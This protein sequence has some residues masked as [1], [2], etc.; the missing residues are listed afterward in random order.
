V[1]DFSNAMPDANGNF[2]ADPLFVR[3]PGGNGASDFGDLHLQ[4]GSPAIDV[5]NDAA[6]IVPPFPANLNGQPLDLDGNP[7]ISRA[8]VDLGA[9]EYQ[10][11]APIVNAGGN[12]TVTAAHTGNPATDTASLSLNGSATDPENDPLTYTWTDANGNVVGNSLT[13]MLTLHLGAYTYTLTANAPFGASG[14]QSVLITVNPAP[15]QAP[16]ANSQNLSLNQDTSANITLDGS[17]PDGDAIT[18]AIATNPAHGTLSGTVP[19]LTYT[20]NSGFA[21]SDSFT[22]TVSDPYGAASASAT[23]SLTVKD[24]TPPV[25]TLNGSNPMTVNQGSTFTD[26]GAT[27][28]DNVDGSVPVT[29]SG[30]VNTAVP[31]P[32]TLTYS[33]QDSAGNKATATRTVNVVAVA[34][35]VTVKLTAIGELLGVVGV[36]VT[37]QNSGSATIN[38]VKITSA[39]LIDVKAALILPNGFSLGA[40]KSQDVALAFYPLKKGQKGTLS[41]SGSYSGGTF[42]LEQ[43]VTIP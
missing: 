42:S 17:D 20:P 16:S 13:L 33:A 43:S 9:Y 7:R 37:V 34:P 36:V 12:Q 31:G 29:V 5:G 22:F 14:H 18:Y 28:V 21:G 4:W 8:H 24:T 25:I 26:P 30:S 23:I 2:A 41:I 1:Q 32:Y 6:V 38:N 11:L 10:N 27:A 35:K 3:N 39:S 15:N 40:G 19:N